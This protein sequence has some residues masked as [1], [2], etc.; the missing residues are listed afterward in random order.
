MIK[1]NTPQPSKIYVFP[2]VVVTILS[3]SLTTSIILLLRQNQETDRLITQNQI[4]TQTLPTPTPTTADSRTALT[5]EQW[6]QKYFAAVNDPKNT[7][8]FYVTRFWDQPN[9]TVTYTSKF[10]SYSINF[11]YNFAWGDHE[12]KVL[13]YEVKT[14]NQQSIVQFGQPYQFEGGGMNRIRLEELPPSTI[15]TT[16][17]ALKNAQEETG[18]EAPTFEEITGL[19]FPVLQVE[20]PD[21]FFGGT[22][23]Y[24]VFLPQ[25]TLKLSDPFLLN[26]A[27]ITQLVS[28]VS[29]L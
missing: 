4:P 13:P 28:S 26:R 22:I 7:Y 29:T 2:W 15:S 24:Y 17:L 20:T 3:I 25:V 6:S 19:K 16:S 11:P 1:A 5:T 27:L 21:A 8:D 18:E 12:N 9:S 23:S 14:D 10:Y